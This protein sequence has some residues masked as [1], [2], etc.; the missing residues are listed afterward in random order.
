MSETFATA[1][2]EY[3][4]D[5]GIRPGT[6]VAYDVDVTRI[7]DLTDERTMKRL[8]TRP[9]VLSCAWKLL[10]LVEGKRPPTWGIAERIIQSGANGIRV[11]SVRGSGNNLVLYR[12]QP[13]RGRQIEVLDPLGDLRASRLRK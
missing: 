9:E 5:L 4:Q 10:A 6:L 2:A 11:P 8:G 7:V 1:V 3:E 12:F 13:G